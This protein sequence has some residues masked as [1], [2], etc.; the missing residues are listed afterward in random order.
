MKSTQ[1]PDVRPRAHTIKAACAA[2]SISRPTIYRLAAA[3]KI[4]INKIA[5]RS[6]VHDSEIERIASEGSG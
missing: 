1:P 2:L 3:G 5:G 6:T 4:K